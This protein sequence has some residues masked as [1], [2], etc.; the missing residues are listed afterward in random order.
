[1]VLDRTTLG[2][3]VRPLQRGG[4]L[5]V[6]ADAEDRRKRALALTKKGL[7]AARKA[8]DGWG[9]AQTRFEQAIGLDDAKTLRKLLRKVIAADPGKAGSPRTGGNS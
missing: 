6:T 1:M 7:A 8:M 9:N 5:K 2:R 4:Y 3:N